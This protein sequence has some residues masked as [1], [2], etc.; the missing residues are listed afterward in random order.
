[1]TFK[2]TRSSGSLVLYMDG[3]QA[4]TATGGTQSLT[5]PTRLVMGAQ[6]TLINFLTGDIAE[7][8]I[9]NAP[10][11]D[12]DRIAEENALK[13]KYGLTGGSAPEVPTGLTTI[14]GNRKISCNWAPVAGAASYNLWWATSLSGT[15]NL[16]ATNLTTSSYVD[17]NAL[18]GITNYYEVSSVSACGSSSNS[19]PVAVFLP[20]PILGFSANVSSLTFSWPGWASDWLLYST[21]NL[22]PP[23]FWFPITNAV[24]S[25][26]AQFNVT[27]PMGSGNQFFRLSSP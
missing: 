22:T 6:Q 19:A 4:A 20:R 25:N 26:N 9:F 16:T 3:T 11:S 7:V 12:S 18:S 17:T 27:L 2:R 5:S 24:G 21:T 13:C 1:M 15:Y 10:L 8:K 14:A 23:I